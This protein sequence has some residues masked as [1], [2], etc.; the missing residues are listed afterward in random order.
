MGTSRNSL[1][2]AAA[3]CFRAA[4]LLLRSSTSAVSFACAIKRVYVVKIK[5][6]RAGVRTPL[7]SRSESLNTENGA[8]AGGVFLSPGG[9]G[10][11][12]RRIQ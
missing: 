2:A 4:D 7:S 3:A 11:H 9:D 8:G 1:A 10:P 6:S 12:E 5:L